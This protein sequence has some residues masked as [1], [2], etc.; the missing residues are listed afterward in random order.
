MMDTTSF[1]MPEKMEPPCYC[2]MIAGR[3]RCVSV[4]VYTCVSVYVH[5]CLH[6]FMRI[7][8]FAHISLCMCSLCVYVHVY[9]SMCVFM[10]MLSVW[11]YVPEWEDVCIYTGGCV[12]G[13]VYVCFYVAMF[14]ICM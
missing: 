10:Y 14:V 4:C 13:F 5:L 7:Y 6:Y 1:L 11:C 8:M 2:Y 12:R 9:L 3:C